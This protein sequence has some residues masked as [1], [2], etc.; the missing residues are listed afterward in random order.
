MSAVTIPNLYDEYAEWTDNVAQYPKTAEASYLALGIADEWGELNQAVGEFFLAEA[1]DVC[2][3]LARYCTK[4][5]N[6]SFSDAVELSKAYTPAQWAIQTH[7]GIIAGVEK[8]RI[9]DGENWDSETRFRKEGSAYGAVK[10]LITTLNYLL[11]ARGYSLAEA[12]HYNMKKLSKR[13]EAGT[14]KGDGDVR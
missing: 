9:R 4:V 14:I 11:E 1:G 10:N 3:Y 5:L 6:V 13:L 8:K 7:I 12:L 2:W